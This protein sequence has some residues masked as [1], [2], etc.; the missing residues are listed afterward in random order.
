MDYT[1]LNNFFKL[2]KG[3]LKKGPIALIFAEDEKELASTIIHHAK[4]GFAKIIVFSKSI[5]VLPTSVE[6]KIISVHVDLFHSSG[7]S[8]I[9]NKINDLAQNQWIYFCYNAEYLFYPFCETRSVTE[10]LDFHSEERRQA[11]L[12]YVVDLYPNDLSSPKRATSI[13]NV[14]LDGTGYFALARLDPSTHQPLDRQLDYFGGLRWRFEEYVPFNQGKINRVSIFKSSKGLRISADY[15]FD[16]QEYNTYAC[17]W[18][19]NLTAAVVSLRAAKALMTNPD[20]KAEIEDL[21]WQH[22]IPFEW[23]S[24]QL[25]DLGLIEPGQWF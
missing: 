3:H 5:P 21:S 20:S 7:V 6:N 12:T 18:H 23:R 14:H 1:S 24:T 2:G 13:E 4:L 15:T 8:F 11:M 9:L 10:L 17:P 22:S 16:N 25:L 19:S